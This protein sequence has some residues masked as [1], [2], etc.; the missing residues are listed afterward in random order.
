[1]RLMNLKNKSLKGTS[2]YIV[3]FPSKKFGVIGERKAELLKKRVR[4]NAPGGSKLLPPESKQV[5]SSTL[6]KSSIFNQ[7]LGF[8]APLLGQVETRWAGARGI[9]GAQ[10]SRFPA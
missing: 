9:K 7:I 10:K 5:T 4:K 1:M 2:T 3:N 6:K 8:C